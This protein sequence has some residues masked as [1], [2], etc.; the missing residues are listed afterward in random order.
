MD[1]LLWAQPQR[2]ASAPCGHL[3]SYSQPPE[4]LSQKSTL[5]GLSHPHHHVVCIYFFFFIKV[6]KQRQVLV[7]SPLL[8]SSCCAPSLEACHS[9]QSTTDNAIT[10]SFLPALHCLHWRIATWAGPHVPS[11][12]AGR[13][14]YQREPA[15]H[16]HHIHVFMV[17]QGLVHLSRLSA[18]ELSVFCMTV[19]GQM[20]S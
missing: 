8:I 17:F 14:W 12:M 5:R 13:C 10:K 1:F 3:S 7:F 2:G 18:L 9:A 6:C 19:L 20:G 11:S 16:W 4:A 15:D